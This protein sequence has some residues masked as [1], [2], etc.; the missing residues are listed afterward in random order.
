MTDK[1]FYER[2]R[3]ANRLGYMNLDENEAQKYRE[4]NSKKLTNQHFV[5]D[6]NIGDPI[7]LISMFIVA[8]RLSKEIRQ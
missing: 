7:N 3:E 5:K 1:D 2:V 6:R 4:I 8:T